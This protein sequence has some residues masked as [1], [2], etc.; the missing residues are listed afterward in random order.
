MK[1]VSGMGSASHTNGS[2]VVVYDRDNAIKW[3]NKLLME[4]L[5]FKP[6]GTLTL[7][8]SAKTFGGQK[9]G[10]AQICVR[11]GGRNYTDIFPIVSAVEFVR[12]MYDQIA[13]MAGLP[14][15]GTVSAKEDL[16]PL[17]TW[18]S[19]CPVIDGVLCAN[20]VA[21][22]VG[23]NGPHPLE[24]TPGRIL[25]MGAN[26]QLVSVEEKA[27]LADRKKLRLSVEGKT[28]MLG[29]IL[30]ARSGGG[31]G[32]ET[33][34]DVW[35]KASGSLN[36]FRGK[37]YCEKNAIEAKL[38]ELCSLFAVEGFLNSLQ[39]KIANDVRVLSFGADIEG[40]IPVDVVS[41]TLLPNLNR[42]YRSVVRMVEDLG[43]ICTSPLIVDEQYNVSSSRT[44]SIP[45]LTVVEVIEP[46]LPT[47]AAPQKPQQLKAPRRVSHGLK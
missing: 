4:V 21:F 14:T 45:S 19:Y 34:Y 41:Q 18:A 33:D 44:L 38:K 37:R 29:D 9:I 24:V 25:C 32:P 16:G 12:G 20:C 2:G 6:T 11:K 17:P 43:K 46:T 26:G 39:T 22:I 31:Y 47:S 35:I 23:P 7:L 5:V 15:S 1:W 40:C 42:A 13:Q 30:D 8:D 3:F 10:R 27:F 28:L 36:E